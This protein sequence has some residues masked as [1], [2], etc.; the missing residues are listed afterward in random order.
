[1]PTISRF[2]GIVVFMNYSDH[3]PPHFHARHQHQE[4][5]VEIESGIVRGTMSRHA[6][7]M[8]IEWSERHQEALLRDWQLAQARQPLEQIPPLP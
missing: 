5:I 4:V 1:M 7:R 2:Y 8:V 6:L 3:Q